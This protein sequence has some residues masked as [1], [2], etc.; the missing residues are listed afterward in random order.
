MSDSEGVKTVKSGVLRLSDPVRRVLLIF[1]GGTWLAGGA[2]VFVPDSSEPGGVALIVGGM[3]CILV[4]AIG[5]VPT[6]VSGSNWSV[7]MSDE[8]VSVVEDRPQTERKK[9]IDDILANASSDDG[10]AMRLASRLQR[11]VLFEDEAIS[12]L[13]TLLAGVPGVIIEVPRGNSDSG[14]DAVLTVG[15]SKRVGVNIKFSSSQAAFKSNLKRAERELLLSDFDGYL[16][17]LNHPVPFTEVSVVGDKW[18]WAVSF[19]NLDLLQKFFL[20]ANWL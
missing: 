20:R 4:G 9:I 2:S 16:L 17:L 10:D 3:I 14:A 15:S 1:G 7:D 8:I 18:L 13:R 12:R 6:R 11:G 5:F 19:E